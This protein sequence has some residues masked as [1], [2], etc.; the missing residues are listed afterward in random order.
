MITNR[1]I[2]IFSKIR[3]GNTAF[4]VEVTFQKKVGYLA[5]NRAARRLL[6]S[7]HIQKEALRRGS[8]IVDETIF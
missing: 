1:A 8:I 3:K 7:E 6:A 5:A 2:W 4:F